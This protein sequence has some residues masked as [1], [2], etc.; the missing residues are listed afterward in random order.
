MD[1]SND[2][3]SLLR[4]FVAFVD[5]DEPEAL[6]AE[7][8]LARWLDTLALAMH[9]VEHRFDSSISGLQPP[10]RDEAPLRRSIERRFPRFGYYNVPE[11][12]TGKIGEDPDCLLG[13][14]VDDVLDIAL[15][16]RNVEWRW[17]NI[18]EDDAL[19]YL[20]SSYTSHWREHLRGLQ[21]YLD[22]LERE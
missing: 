8:R 10:S 3:R 1:D 11:S 7:E 4:G 19:W 13:D 21:L 15:E 9:D 6:G 14:A 12:V 18:S 2:L 16:L 22:A 17:Q 20:K 5:S